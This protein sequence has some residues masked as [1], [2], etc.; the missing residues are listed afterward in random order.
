DQAGGCFVFAAEVV[1]Q[2]QTVRIYGAVMGQ[3]GQLPGA[4]AATTPLVRAAAASLHLHRVTGPADI[5]GEY[6]SA[7]GTR[8][9]MAPASE[10]ALVTYDGIEVHRSVALREVSAAL[11][12]GTVVGTLVL[13]AGD[14]RVSVSLRTVEPMA[15]RGFWWRV[16]RGSYD[17]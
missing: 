8:A 13:L 2:G 10:V 4:F 16:C 3:P 9:R 7:W 1:V 15:D 6:Q 11:P 12:S 17:T 14:Q 5:V